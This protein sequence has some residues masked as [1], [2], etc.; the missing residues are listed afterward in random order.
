MDEGKIDINKGRIDINKVDNFDQFY[1][2]TQPIGS[3]EQGLSN[4]LYGINHTQSKGVVTENR[5]SYGLTFF[6]RPQ[7]NMS[8]P[9][10]RNIRQM[11]SLLTNKTTSIHRYI[12]CMLDPR[13]SR[14]RFINGNKEASTK[15]TTE[16]VDENMP[17]IPILT[18]NLKSMSG[19]PDIIAPSYT[20]TA[21]SRKEQW[22][23]VDG[24]IEVNDSFDIDATFRNTKNEPI[25]MMMQT[26]LLYMASVFEGMLSPYLDYITTNR[27]DYNTRIYRL[28]L[29]E[30]KRYV[31]KIAA[32]G[33]SFPVN[34]P[35]G[36]FFDYT[37]EKKYNDQTKDIN[38]RFK[39]MGA[40][41]NDPILIV[42]FNEVSAIFNPDV[43]NMLNGVT[44]SLKKIPYE[45]LD[46]LNHRGYPIIN[47]DTYELEWWINKNDP[48][49]KKIEKM[50]EEK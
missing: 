40:T 9:N 39:C 20:S 17:F 41:Y 7:L 24:S 33:A 18:N 46:K 27:I 43:R 8:T 37:D 3:V 14:T 44:H 5:D 19:W 4:N 26:W 1:S 11:Y 13:L 12:R 10:L 32:T 30:S 42:E 23:I 50:L 45:L 34:V 22:S 47:R 31:K 49:Y 25:V 6:T 2:L 35:V 48:T 15:I 36:K 38:I 21:G 29:D 16:L 28:V